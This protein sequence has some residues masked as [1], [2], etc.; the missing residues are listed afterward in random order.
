MQNKPKYYYHITSFDNII[1]LNRDG[2]KSDNEGQIFLLD[3]NE[4]SIVSTVACNQCFLDDYALFRIDSKGILGE[5]IP[6][7]V[8]ESTAKYQFIAKQESIDPKYIRFINCYRIGKR[9]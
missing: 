9:K 7:K 5:L 4:A 2:I 8:A 1:S 6:D 3:T